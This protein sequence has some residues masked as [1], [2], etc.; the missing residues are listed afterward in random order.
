VATQ[1]DPT[2]ATPKSGATKKSQALDSNAC[3]SQALA[4]DRAVSGEYVDSR[5]AAKSEERNV[6]PLSRGALSNP[7]TTMARLHKMSVHDLR[8]LDALNNEG[9]QIIRTRLMSI[10]DEMS[11][12]FERG[13]SINGISGT[14]GKGMGKY[15]RSIGIDP[16]KRRSWKFEIAQQDIL[17]LAQESPRR[18]RSTKKKEIVIHSETEADLIAQAG[19]KMAQQLVGDSAMP[20]QERINKAEAVAKEILN[21]IEDGQYERLEPLPSAENAPLPQ[22]AN[23]VDWESHQIPA[24]DFNLKYFA[25]ASEDFKDRYC[26]AFQSGA[27]KKILGMLKSKPEQVL[28]NAHDFAQLSAVLRGAAD[29]L[30]L[31][32]A[33]IA[34]ALTPPPATGPGP[35][36]VEQRNASDLNIHPSDQPEPKESQPNS[37]VPG[38][39]EQ[40]EAWLRRYLRNGPMPI[41]DSYIKS[42]LCRYNYPPGQ[43]PPDGVGKKT[44]DKAIISLGIQKLPSGPRGGIRWHLPTPEKDGDQAVTPG[45]TIEHPQQAEGAKE[46]D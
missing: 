34:T 18:K 40:A 17:R 14:G 12:R 3:A 22:T 11:V 5:E 19:V 6:E 10:W 33:V 7:R 2:P 1:S 39:L 21:A 28:L 38:K 20:P 45:A 15:L 8:V 44:I 42:G 43:L 37:V 4:P 27:F 26:H 25:G 24:P 23:Y 9:R 29:N 16:A 41:P 46:Q 36:P 13:E 31:L 30:N 32:A 35:A